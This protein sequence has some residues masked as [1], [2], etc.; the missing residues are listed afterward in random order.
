MMAYGFDRGGGL[1]PG[2]MIDTRRD[3]REHPTNDGDVVLIVHPC[4]SCVGKAALG[5]YNPHACV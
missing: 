4:R 2:F 5:V 3:N 1:C